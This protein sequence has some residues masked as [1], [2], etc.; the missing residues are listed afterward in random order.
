M[1]PISYEF[2]MILC[3]VMLQKVNS[4]KEAAKLQT[5][6]KHGSEP[7]SPIPDRI[8]DFLRRNSPS[9]KV[10]YIVCLR[11]PLRKMYL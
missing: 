3:H 6:F 9:A 4:K 10:D 5:A 2:R 11:Q 8:L 1:E 7:S